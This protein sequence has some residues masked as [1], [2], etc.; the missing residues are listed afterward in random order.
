MAYEDILKA[1]KAIQATSIVTHNINFAKKK[2]KR[3]NDF[4][5]VGATNIVGSELLKG[6]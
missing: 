6:W 2:K 5:E 1:A 4:V 3:L